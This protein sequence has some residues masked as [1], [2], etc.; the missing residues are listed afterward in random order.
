MSALDELALNPALL[1][2]VGR[3]ICIRCRTYPV[4]SA[5]NVLFFAAQNV[6]DELLR[7]A[8]QLRSGKDVEFRKA[9]GPTL[10]YQIKRISGK[11]GALEEGGILSDLIKSEVS[12]QEGSSLE[13]IKKKSQSEPVIKLVNNLVNQAILEIAT[14][15]HIEPGEN[16]VKVRYRKDGMLKDSMELPKWVQASLTSRIKILAELD[17]AEKRLPQ[18]GRIKWQHEGEAIDMRVSTLPTRVGEKV[19]IRILKHMETVGNMESLGMSAEVYSV[20][21]QLIHRPQGMLFVTG[22]TGSGKSSTL[23]ASL[24]EILEKDINVSTIEDPIEYRLEGANQVQIND[25][26]GLTFA[27]AL[28]SLLRQDP[29]VIMVGEIRDEETAAIAVQAA[30][31]GHLVFSTLHTNDAASVV[32]RLLDLKIKP[33]LISS[34]VLG[35]MSQ[36][37]VRKLCQACFTMQPPT[38]EEK[39]FLPMLPALCPTAVGCPACNGTGYRGR[40]GIFELLQFDTHIREAILS[41]K[42]EAHI[43]KTSNYKQL[44]MDGMDKLKQNITSAGELIRVAVMEAQT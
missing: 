10:E 28:R 15:I 12:I 42:S 21:K 17:I 35:V 19:V 38:K 25:K 41:G 20:I 14:D 40:T 32:T 24:K 13:E 43:K 11:A 16:L 30:Q 9:D 22:P 5:G 37:L 27:G 44:V 18:D 7:E 6:N 8:L 4:A 31:T 34:A 23:Y 29:D 33:F 36:R 39:M 1:D 26:A 2:E 3:D